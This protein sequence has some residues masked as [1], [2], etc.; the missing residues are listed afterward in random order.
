MLQ[1]FIFEV[2]YWLRSTMLWIFTGI[3]ALLILLA[4]STDQVTVGG[5]IGNTLRNAPFVIQQYYSILWF[6]T[7]LMTVVFVNSAA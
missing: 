1:F 3:V 6:I 4:L 7:L 2:R 5:A